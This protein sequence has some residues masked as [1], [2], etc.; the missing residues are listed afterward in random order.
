MTTPPE[1][2]EESIR[3]VR[4][5]SDRT[6]LHYREWMTTNASSH[7]F[8]F[9]RDSG[10]TDRLRE[11][12]HTTEELCEQ[13]S[14]DARTTELVLDCL[15]SLGFVERYGDDVALAR[16]GHLLCQYDHDLGD[17]IW[18]TL[19]ERSRG[20]ADSA[21]SVLEDEAYRC[22]IAAT[23]WIHTSA[24]MQA[25]EMLEPERG[26]TSLLDLGCGAAVWSCAMAHRAPELSVTAVDHTKVLAAARGTVDSIELGSRFEFVASN[27]LDAELPE[28]GFDLVLLPQVLSGYGETDAQRLLQLAARS[29]KKGGRIAI[30]DLYVGPSKAGIDEVT[31]R[32]SVRLL[33]RDG[34]VRDLR[35]CQSLMLEAGFESIQFTYLA[36][37]SGGL[38]ML[39]ASR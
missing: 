25:A 29:L 18:A 27:P 3:S 9:A 11:R 6:I 17:A 37:S 13:L 2:T 22:R 32:L 16:A 24:A 30:P 39:V 21:A 31:Q 1:P 23:Q 28:A 8:R 35:T 36:A 19:S 33:T 14:L 5:A 26:T 10:I 34:E 4:D 38:A 12:Q 7:L 20:T 15:A